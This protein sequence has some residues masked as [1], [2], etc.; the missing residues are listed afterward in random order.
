MAAGMTLPRAHFERF[1]QAF[2]ETVRKQLA[3]EDLEAVLW[4]DGELGF[5][6]LSLDLAQQLRD[7]GPWGQ[8]FPEPLFDGEFLLVNQRLVGERHLK[9]VLADPANPQRTID[10]IAFQVDTRQWPNPDVERLRI[11]YR[12]DINEWK[13]RQSVQ[14]I[15][16]Y[17]EPAA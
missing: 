5:D 16:E 12:V 13:G 6:D 1:A 10:A 3:A 15:V 17:L 14:L 8:H 11:A 9:M 2:D 7:G 4:S